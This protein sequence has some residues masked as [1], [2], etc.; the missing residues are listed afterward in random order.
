MQTP[1]TPGWPPRPAGD[2]RVRVPSRF[3]R[4]WLLGRDVEL[5]FL[6]DMLDRAAEGV[7]SASIVRGDA[8]IGKSTLLGAV[9]ERAREGAMMVL[10]TRGV[11]SEA[12]LP[13]AGL[14]QLLSPLL[15]RLDELGRVQRS[16]LLAAFGVQ[17]AGIADP[18]RIALAALELLTDAA[19]DGP[20]VL[21]ADDAQLLD[22]PTVDVLTF[23]ARRLGAD[24]I[25]ALF[26]VR[27]EAIVGA[28]L[29]ELL[30]AP[31]D[32]VAS[33]A[34]LRQCAPDLSASTRDRVLREAAGNPL[35][36]AELPAALQSIDEDAGP[37]PDMLPLTARLER[38]FVDRMEDLP[39]ET[40]ALLLAAA[41]DP[42]CGLQEL[43]AAAG[44]VVGRPL[45]VETVDP[46]AEAGL[47]DVDAAGHV[48]FR[49]PLMA[50]AIH[51]AASFGDRVTGHDA[52]ADA[53]DPLPAREVWHGASAA[54]GV[55][56]PLSIEVERSAER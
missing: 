45:P 3:G 43:L 19:S 12:H 29:E 32:R 56:E 46:A 36:L 49:H 40:S 16:S 54:V 52:V 37:L 13:F 21:V 50:S 41:I 53:L 55:E 31:L 15:P 26:A 7:G 22:G 23:V 44:A 47:V 18:F 25:V 38:S 30:V 39:A 28:G 17:D 20:L 8:G 51:Q 42:A 5:A 14:H 48:L 10:S 33:E 2:A 6:F 11:Q 1:S 9:V 4:P 35:A 34:L 24:P 27:G